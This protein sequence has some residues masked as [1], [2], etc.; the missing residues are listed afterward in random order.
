VGIAV[1]DLDK[2]IAQYQ[3]LF[4]FDSIEKTDFESEGVRL[5]LLRIGTSEIELLSPMSDNSI[6]KF[7]RERGEGI[8]HL[9]IRVD[10]VQDAIAYAKSLGLRMIDDRPR[11]GQGGA[12]AAFIHPKSMHGVLLEFYN[13]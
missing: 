4:E 6:A 12:E 3:E 5:A 9:A 7:I 13:H 2:A 11:K 1:S 8:H 10:N